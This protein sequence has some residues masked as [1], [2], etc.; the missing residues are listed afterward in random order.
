MSPGFCAG[1]GSSSDFS[2]SF[3]FGFGFSFGFGFGF[4]F[5]PVQIGGRVGVG[6]ELTD[7]PNLHDRSHTHTHF[8]PTPTPTPTVSLHPTLS[9]SLTRSLTL[10]PHSH[11]HPHPSLPPL[12][13]SLAAELGSATCHVL[14]APRASNRFTY[15]WGGAGDTIHN[16]YEAPPTVTSV[17]MTYDAFR[18][19]RAKTR[20]Q[21][22]AE[23]GK[24]PS[25]R[26]LKNG[27]G[28]RIT[29]KTSLIDS[30]HSMTPNMA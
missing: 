1:F 29:W 21:H 24:T 25:M 4:S 17:G 13:A 9:F 14:S 7:P 3:G 10:N 22:G 8:S 27:M 2:S 30:W 11:P 6:V 15:F 20:T 5:G 19:E 28:L 12:G 18:S 23:H 16:S 26:S